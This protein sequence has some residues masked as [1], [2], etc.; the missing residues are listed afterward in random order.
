MHKNEAE[1]DTSGIDLSSMS[2]EQH[3]QRITALT[4]ETESLKE[5]LATKL[6]LL[7]A[8]K[9]LSPIIGKIDV[10][11]TLLKRATAAGQGKK[12]F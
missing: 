9:N 12:F 10:G 7:A 1:Q 11:T 4:A 6:Q 8:F 5:L 2:V 3:E